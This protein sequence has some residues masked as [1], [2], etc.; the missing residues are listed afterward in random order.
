MSASVRILSHDPN[1]PDILLLR[2]R[3]IGCLLCRG[4]GRL[5]DMRPGKD[6]HGS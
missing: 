6:V 1:V 3:D 2:N 5:H 4:I